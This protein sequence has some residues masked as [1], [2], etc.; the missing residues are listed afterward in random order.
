MGSF[1]CLASGGQKRGLCLAYGAV[2]DTTFIAFTSPGASYGANA[3]SIY[4]VWGYI[5]TAH[6]GDSSVTLTAGSAVNAP[7][8]YVGQWMAVMALD[9]QNAFGAQTSWPNNNQYFEYVQI[10]AIDTVTKTI[11]F[12][13][14]LRNHYPSTLPT[15]F[16]GT[17]GSSLGNPGQVGGGGAAMVLGY[18]FGWDA[19][20]VYKGLHVTDQNTQTLNVSRSLTFQDC[21]F[22]VQSGSPGATMIF[23]A[24]NCL[25]G[26]GTLSGSSG[27]AAGSV[28]E[29]DKLLE[30][31][32]FE[33]CQMQSLSCPSPSPY[34]MTIRNCR[35]N[36][37][38]GSGQIAQIQD[39]YINQ[40]Y[41][42]SALGAPSRLVL[43]N[44][45]ID[46]IGPWSRLDDPG[47]VAG[48][49]NAV[50]YWTFSNGTLKQPITRG[51][52]S[53]AVP[54]RF[55]YV[56]H[57]DPHAPNG[58]GAQD[59][60]GS[61]FKILDVY[62]SDG[63]TN[64]AIDTTLAAMPV[65]PQTTATVTLNSGTPGTVTWA[66][67]LAANTAVMFLTAAGATLPA[68]ITLGTVYYVVT[69]GTSPFSVSTTPGGG[70]INF[71]SSST[72]TIT[73]VANPLHFQPHPCPN[74][75]VRGCIGD[76]SGSSGTIAEM[77]GITEQ[78]LYSY[79]SRTFGG[80]LDALGS[81]Y[82]VALVLHGNLIQLTVNVIKAYTGA[83]GYTYTWVWPGYTSALAVSN[84]TVVIDCTLTGVRTITPTAATGSQGVDVIAAY[85]GWIGGVQNSSLSGRTGG[86]GATLSQL[87][88]FELTVTTDQGVA[89]FGSWMGSGNQ[90]AHESLFGDAVWQQYAP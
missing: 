86:G 61:M 87:P 31:V 22:D 81:S 42:G 39:S 63:G 51:A 66:G 13:P 9:L 19:E 57:L 4:N 33:D 7:N 58:G 3:N 20:L 37:M 47:Q 68:A 2:F 56:N 43:I 70:A 5:N 73:G 45:R 17:P 83:G 74:L 78:P 90:Q 76:Y 64:L 38:Y 36:T 23:R 50:A 27:I 10:T 1:S 88:V 77:N 84:F 49:T 11:S 44:S 26:D 89:R 69:P 30:H 62:V 21:V 71:A 6:T 54:G 25:W 41:V 34:I 28:V 65:G 75:T 52:V 53:W 59:N 80:F 18:S 60:M 79:A 32:E 85:T 15:F 35:I 48:Y 29:V 24:K 40:L 14:R 12:N 82:T 46:T 67:G 55:M 8:F 72:G 16:G